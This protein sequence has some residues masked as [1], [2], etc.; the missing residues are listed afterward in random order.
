MYAA[1]P[2]GKHYEPGQ[3]DTELSLGVMDVLVNYRRVAEWVEPEAKPKRR[4][5]APVH[6]GRGH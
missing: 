1:T 4:E 3:I 5:R 6:S 2:N